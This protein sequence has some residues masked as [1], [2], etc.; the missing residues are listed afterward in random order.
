MD[1]WH[2]IVQKIRCFDCNEYSHVAADC[3][4]KITPSDT[5]ACHGKHHSNMR[6][7]TRSTSRHHNRT[8]TGLADPD[9]VCALTDTEVTVKITHREVTPGHIT[10]VPTEAH[11]AT[12]TQ[13]LIVTNGDTPHR[14]S[15][16][17][18]SSSM[19]SRDCSVSRPH[20]LYKTS[21]T[22]S[23]KPSYNSNKTA[24]KHKDKKYRKVTI[25]NPPSDYYSSDEPSSD[26][27]EDLY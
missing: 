1:T 27:E 22:A 7:Q 25:D 9:H 4:D 19:H 13:T 21:Q 23:S 15:S 11:H 16:L 26:S 5:P 6:H 24:W 8:D 17:H 3:P 12:D 20:T 14:R 10:G 2:T 18:R